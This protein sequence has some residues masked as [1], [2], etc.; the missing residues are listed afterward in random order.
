[1]ITVA[2]T[3]VADLL[4]RP[5][6][7]WEGKGH[8]ANVDCIEL[9]PGGTV[10]NTGFALARLGVP[11]SALGAIGDD[12]FGVVVNESVNRWAAR[13]RVVVLPSTPTTASV[14]AVFEDGDRCFL[15]AAGA[16]EQ[17][18]LTP[19]D[20]SS[21][22]EAGS[23]ALHLGYAGR[24]PVLDGEP[25]KNLMRFAHKHGA[26]TSLDV[27]Y[28]PDDRWPDLMTLMP[29]LDLFCPNLIEATAITGRNSASEA[30]AALVEAGVQKFVAVT[31]G[32]NGALVHIVGEGQEPIPA[33]PVKVV[34][35]TGAGDA[36]IAGVLAAWYRGCSWRIAAQMGVLVSSTAVTSST[37]YENLRSFEELIPEVM[38]QNVVGRSSC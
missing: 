18:D 30:A 3:L 26:L 28:F 35:T 14:V 22:I 21:E 27:T 33:R 17:F 29:E 9:L 34:D 24:L 37:R 5:I 13:N 1:M 12:S 38:K 23:R 25:M 19:A 6:R 10:A 16:S 15:S 31:D 2:G 36:F 4:V 11:V 32:A 7:N 8:N 20:V